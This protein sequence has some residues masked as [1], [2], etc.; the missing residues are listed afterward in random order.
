MKYTCTHACGHTG[1]IRLS[2]P[3]K[4]RKSLQSWYESKD[5]EE[6]RKQKREQVREQLLAEAQQ[7]ASLC[8]FPALS[9]SERQIAWAETIRYEFCC[10]DYRLQ[11]TQGQ[12]IDIPDLAYDRLF[13]SPMG[14]LRQGLLHQ[15]KKVRCLPEEEVEAIYVQTVDVDN[16]VLSQS[17]LNRTEAKW[18]IDNRDN[19]TYLA[20][21]AAMDTLQ[22]A[23]TAIQEGRDWR[24]A[25]LEKSDEVAQARELAEE[26]AETLIAEGE[27]VTKGATPVEIVL[28]ETHRMVYVQYPR[29]DDDLY[30]IVKGQGTYGPNGWAI[31]AN[32]FQTLDDIVAEFATR[33]IGAGFR[34]LLPSQKTLAMVKDAS[35]TWHPNRWCIL[36]DGLFIVQWRGTHDALYN[37]LKRCGGR[38]ESG[39]M[40]V[41]VKAWE[42]VEGLCDAHK[43]TL[44]KNASEYIEAQKAKYSGAYL[45][46]PAQAP[47]EPAPNSFDPASAAPDPALRDDDED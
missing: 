38:W 45:V 25:I 8:G 41:P 37:G 12:R 1:T 21:E 18:W 40:R 27:S 47:Q 26:A 46:D 13:R 9:G 28:S 6:C 39:C 43:V 24:E 10:V 31:P 35:F 44:S 15:L 33:L 14:A 7:Y 22:I 5:C 20:G 17:L 30:P 16:E 3:T 11:Q 32:P 34:V 2:G 36:K 4:S 23:Y 42:I 29:K 19:L